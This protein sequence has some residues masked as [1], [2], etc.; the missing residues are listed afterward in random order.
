MDESPIGKERILRLP[1]NITTSLTKTASALCFIGMMAGCDTKDLLNPTAIVRSGHPAEPLMVPILGTIDPQIENGP[2]DFSSAVTP[3]PADMVSSSNDYTIGRNDLLNIAISDLM[4]PGQE[5]LKTARVSESGNVSL[6]YLGVVHAAGLTEFELEQGIIKAY[7]DANLIQNAQVS[8][9]VVEARGR[10]VEILGAVVAPGQYAILD[11][12]F[13]LLDALVLAKDT[14]T[15]LTEWIY[16]IRKSESQRADKGGVHSLNLTPNGANGAGSK[17]P[18]SG[19][20]PDD[21][22]P[23]SDSGVHSGGAVARSA[24]ANRPLAL[25]AD[26]PLPGL[27]LPVPS[28]ATTQPAGTTNPAEQ[29]AATQPFEFNAPATPGHMR[30]IKIPYQGLRAGD[31]SY[32][33]AVHPRD[34]II[35]QNLG[36]GEYYM[37]GHVARP[38]VFTLS[39]R[40]ITLK[41]AIISAGGFDDLAI[42]QRTDIIRRIKPDREVFVRIDLERIFSGESPDLYLKPDDQILVGTNMLAPFL[43]AVRGAFRITYGFGFLYDRN[44][45]YSSNSSGF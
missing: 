42:P 1:R 23:K 12:D 13:R 39:G 41:Q 6:P 40:R 17:T 16:V 9:T 26:A 14:T 22:A 31:L 36:V 24:T 18:T 37:G 38:G 8:V 33:I 44:Y 29:G 15:P 19:P 28:E 10:T 21:L 25:L 7:R 11:A 34:L 2:A 4:G 45:A 32:N 5:T 35:V 30:V 43:S 20:S 27:D 3:T